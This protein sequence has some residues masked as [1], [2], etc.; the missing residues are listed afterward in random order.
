MRKYI[1]GDDVELREDSAIR[2]RVVA[3]EDIPGL[4][5][6]VMVEPQGMKP[7]PLNHWQ[8]PAVSVRLVFAADDSLVQQASRARRPVIAETVDTRTADDRAFVADVLKAL[9][10]HNHWEALELIAKLKEAAKAYLAPKEDTGCRAGFDYRIER[11]ELRS[12]IA[13]QASTLNEIRKH[14]T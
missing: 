5:Q 1:I 4:G 3:I 9:D 8:A 2:G 12:M 7:D 11:D 10:T 14:L 6:S 13:K